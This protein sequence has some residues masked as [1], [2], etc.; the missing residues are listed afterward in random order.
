MKDYD[1]YYAPAGAFGLGVIK[2]VYFATAIDAEMGRASGREF[3]GVKIV[4]S[5]AE[6]PN[7]DIE[8][9]GCDVI[10]ISWSVL[11]QQLTEFGCS[12][13]P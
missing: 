4:S 8:D 11:A 12:G 9:G 1:R 7:D 3:G 2:G 5:V 6:L 10:S 13:V